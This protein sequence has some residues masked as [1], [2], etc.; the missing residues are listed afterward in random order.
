MIKHF[1]NI[2]KE[3]EISHNI[4]NSD[5]NTKQLIHDVSSIPVMFFGRSYIFYE[6]LL[7]WKKF[8]KTGKG[9]LSEKINQGLLCGRIFKLMYEACVDKLLMGDFLQTSNV[10][11]PD[12]LAQVVDVMVD[13][14]VVKGK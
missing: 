8:S 9:S 11:Y 14:I 12:A 1:Y 4:E 5:E 6:S 3:L 2:I 7:N 10:D 13:G